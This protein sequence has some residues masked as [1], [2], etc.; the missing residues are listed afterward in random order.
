MSK[1][2]VKRR[3]RLGE[4]EEKTTPTATEA[5]WWTCTHRHGR[6]IRVRVNP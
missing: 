3:G 1:K 6:R 4:P 5:A 2:R